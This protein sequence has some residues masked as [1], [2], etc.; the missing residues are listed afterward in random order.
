MVMDDDETAREDAAGGEYR[1]ALGEQCQD[2]TPTGGAGSKLGG[3]D[4]AC[5]TSRAHEPVQQALGDERARGSAHG[6]A[7]AVHEPAHRGVAE[8]E[9]GGDLLVTVAMHGRAHERLALHMR[10][11][12]ELGER[13]VHAQALVEL[14]GGR[15][16]DLAMNALVELDIVPAGPAQ[17]VVDGVVHD[18]VH[19]A[20]HVADL[21]AAG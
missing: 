1:A 18:A 17:R 4:D 5:P 6:D 19:P 11:S 20:L 2:P 9:R 13:G 7:R 21:I 3:S 15:D 10:Q 12:G 14:A 8:S 16:R